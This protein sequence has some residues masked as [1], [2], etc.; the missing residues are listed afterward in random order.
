MKKKII[1][2]LDELLKRRTHPAIVSEIEGIKAQVEK[3]DDWIPVTERLPEHEDEV[4]VTV[5]E[6]GDKTFTG[7]D[8]CMSYDGSWF[9]WGSFPYEVI[10]WKEL[11]E[12][13]EGEKS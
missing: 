11:P 4:I 12:P 6:N 3:M 10:A 8:W 7:I 2:Y 13:Y 1:A 5:I 9:N